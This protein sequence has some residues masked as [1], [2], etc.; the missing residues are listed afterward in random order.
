ME[1]VRYWAA[2]AFTAQNGCPEALLS[3]AA[4]DGLHLFAV[5]ALPGGFSGCC[6]ARHYRRLAGRARHLHVRLRVCRRLGLYFRLRP[7]LHRS[8]LW[9][10]LCLFVPL[11][12]CSQQLVWAVDASALTRGQQ[13]RAAAVLRE[14]GLAPGAIVTEARLTAGEYAL[15]QS[16]EF[17]WVSLNFAKGRLE[18]LAAAA[19]PRPDI[20]AGTLHGLRA[21]CAGTVVSANLVSGTLLVAPG[22][23]VE[24][25]QGL[26]GTARAER[27]GTLIFAPAAGT[28]LAQITW[29]NTQDVPLEEPLLRDTGRTCTAWVLHLAGKTLSLPAPAPPGT[30]RS[31]SRHLQAELFGLP[32]PCAVEETTFYE[33]QSETFSRTEAQ[34]LA[35]ARLASLQALQEAF[36]DAELVARKEDA[37][38][39]GAVLHYAVE[40][41]VLADICTENSPGG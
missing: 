2:V 35:L 21:R 34:A 40:Y 10:G 18:V 7:L 27:D 14:A 31:S 3:Q 37:A 25:G 24:A 9:A 29:D 22:Q 6:A 15:L 28:V 12:L 19:K 17:S 16:G 36:P 39:T 32:L 23:A 4:A 26:I 38:C 8:G 41:T 5:S 30:A 1:P 20:A 13:A 33:Q 11:L